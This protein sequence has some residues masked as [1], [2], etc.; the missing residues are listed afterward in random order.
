MDKLPVPGPVALLGSGET[1]PN[2][3]QVF[4]AVA[5]R[6]P[7]PL[8]I[9]I[10]ETPA[11]FELNSP[12]VAGRVADYMKVRL[13]NYQPR[14]ELV[15]AR[16]RGTP[17]SPDDPAA[18]EALLT[19]SL[20]YMGAGSPSYAVR[21][22]NHSLA[23]DRVQARHRLG[24]GLVLASAAAIAVG[25]QA[26]PVYE[27]F[28]VGEDP[29]WKPGLDFF[30]PFGLHL[31]IVSHWNN[32]E[33]GANLDTSR[34]F[35]GRARFDPLLA[36]LGSDLTVLGLDEQTGL[37]LDFETQTAQVFGLDR[38][39]ILRAGGEQSFSKG[40][41]FDFSLL[42]DYQPLEQPSTG[43][44][45]R[46]WQDVLDAA[47]HAAVEQPVPEQVQLLVDQRQQARAER[48]WPAADTIRRAITE[49]GWQVVDT[50][51]G[52][53]VEKLA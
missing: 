53:R 10:L 4:E 24:G 44:D 16:K 15:P 41:R 46:A 27:I 9:G 28:K 39:H 29:H 18:S 33:G 36:Q 51:E 40:D 17:A 43:L 8:Q 14:I 34:C 12:Q 11:G 23:W 37:V 13:Q 7:A 32:A 38:V 30:A 45:G 5:R 20:V 3:G 1:T 42:G 52:P 50:P 31:V 25:K 49:L 6:L 48:N 21:Q 35:I 26:L 47:A 2:G 19:S 22:L